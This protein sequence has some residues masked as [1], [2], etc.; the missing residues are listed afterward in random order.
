[1]GDEFLGAAF[2]ADA[3]G[4]LIRSGRYPG[5][6]EARA[7]DR[8]PL[9]DLLRRGVTSDAVPGLLALVASGPDGTSG[10]ACSLLKDYT[11]TPAV[12]SCFERRWD[13]ASPYLRNRLMWRLLDVEDLD[14]KWQGRFTEFI[15]SEWGTFRAF[16]REF[17]GTSLT[18]IAR[19][20]AR[21]TDPR[22]PSS[23]RWIYLWSIPSLVDER[24]VA[25]TLLS[26]AIASLA[27]TSLRDTGEAILREVNSSP[28]L[29]TPAPEVGSL[30][31]H[32]ESYEFVADAVAAWL[33]EGHQPSEQEANSLNRLPLVDLLRDRVAEDDLGDGLSWLLAVVNEQSGELAALALS[34]L[35]RCSTRA[36][37]RDLLH[38]RWADAAPFLRAHLLWRILDD[39]DLP[40]SWHE[41]LFEFVMSDEGW[42]VFREVSLRFL[43]TP[44]TVVLQALKRIA[45]PSFPDTKKWAYLCRVP[46]V[47]EDREAAKALVTLGLSMEDPFA[48]KVATRLLARFF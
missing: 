33:R 17:F 23:K 10:L 40:T 11:T 8:L 4:A 34:L 31:V 16:N 9:I 42:P 22:F 3:V 19:V 18:G 25:G 14:S 26:G 21:I 1:M 32:T 5:E 24:Q 41:E 43:G 27:D 6:G 30:E 48:R 12:R 46:E 20:L 2:T 13:S 7:I 35:R 38:G 15:R 29:V 37:I 45:D 36:D 44:Q 47:A 39:P 28:S